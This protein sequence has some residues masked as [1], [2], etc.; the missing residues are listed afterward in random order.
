ML[1]VVVLA[2]QTASF[3]QTPAAYTRIPEVVTIN[4]QPANG[5]YV[6]TPNGTVQAYACPAPKPYTNAGGEQGW[7]CF[8][9]ST[10]V[11]L[12]GALP[13]PAAP[14]AQKAQALPQVETPNSDVE[15]PEPQG[16]PNVVYVE[17]PPRVV[18]VEAPPRV[19]YVER[20]PEV[21][22]VEAPPA[23][24]IIDRSGGGG[25]RGDRDRER[26]EVVPSGFAVAPAFTNT[27]AF[28]NRPAFANPGVP[29]T[30]DRNRRDGDRETRRDAVTAAA[31]GNGTAQ[32]GQQDA[33]DRTDASA[34]GR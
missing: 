29:A 14:P 22:Y 12:L 30:D 20:P 32:R 4:G 11:W 7:A 19:I 26:E 31:A 33:R 18:Y 28:V 25:R 13:P 9:P 2:A 23:V 6:M 21:V 16:P 17:A 5:A 10:G 24:V 8:D 1:L 15:L 3:A 27:P 34:R